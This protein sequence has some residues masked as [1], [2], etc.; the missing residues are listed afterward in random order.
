MP[1]LLELAQRLQDTPLATELA[2]SRYEFPILE[3]FHLIGLSLS[4]GLIALLDL[5]LAGLYLRGAPV[6]DVLRQLRPW[7]LVGFVLTFV[8]GALL[9]ASEAVN[10]VKSPVF[11]FKL[12]FILLAGLN[13]L[14][15]EI[16]LARG[17]SPRPDLDAGIKAAGAAGVLSLGLWVLVVASGRLIPY[18]TSW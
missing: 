4:V 11:P 6:T 2:E 18:V 3:G 7:V 15:F 1:L 12:L 16:R 9:F 17:G 8:S 14:Y 5:R 13:A 10:V